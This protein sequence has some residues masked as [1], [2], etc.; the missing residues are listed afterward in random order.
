MPRETDIESKF[1]PRAVPQLAPTGVF[2]HPLSTNS[3]KVSWN[4]LDAS[5]LNGILRGYQVV[6][7]LVDS[8][9][10]KFHGMIFFFLAS[11]RASARLRRR[12]TQEPLAKRAVLV[13]SLVSSPGL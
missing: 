13:F 3:I 10:S 5:K 11:R 12:V 7:Q 9:K 1:V 4:A 6:Y 8:L 2:C